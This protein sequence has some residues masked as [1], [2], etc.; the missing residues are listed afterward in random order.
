[1]FLVR[2][3]VDLPDELY[4]RVKARAAMRGMKLKEYVAAALR[5]SLFE[6]SDGELRETGT[7]YAAECSTLTEDCVLPLIAGQTTEAMRSITEKD[8]DRILEA[9]E[10]D[11]AP[12]AG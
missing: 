11:S 9:D 2:T 5:D 6:R 4:R 1:M 7:E 12:P 3:T 8:I 10:V